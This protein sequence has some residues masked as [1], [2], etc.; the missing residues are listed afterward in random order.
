MQKKKKRKEK[1]RKEKKGDCLRKLQISR[2]S[3]T[4]RKVGCGSKKA[5]PASVICPVHLG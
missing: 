3:D 1:K 4:D 5:P 2:P